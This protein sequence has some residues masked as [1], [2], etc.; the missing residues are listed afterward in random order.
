[1]VAGEEDGNDDWI[2]NGRANVVIP[3]IPAF[4]LVE[5]FPRASHEDLP[6]IHDLFTTHRDI[7]AGRT[8]RRS[9]ELVQ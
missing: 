3:E 4:L 2:T 6:Y 1:M 7:R 9:V 5:T 8:I